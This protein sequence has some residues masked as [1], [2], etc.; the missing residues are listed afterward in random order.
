MKYNIDCVRAILLCLEEHLTVEKA[1]TNFYVFTTVYVPDLFSFIKDYSEEDILYSL[2]KLNEAGFISAGLFQAEGG[3]V[4]DNSLIT[5]ITFE[6]HEFLENIREKK[7]FAT[8]K[9]LAKSAGSFALSV[10]G[11]IARNVALKFAQSALP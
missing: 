10:V 7:N 2:E 11:E 4:C 3:V 5:A 1:D 8:V 9:E 6:G